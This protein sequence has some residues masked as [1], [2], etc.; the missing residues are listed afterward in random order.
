MKLLRRYSLV[1][2]LAIFSLFPQT[3]AR[4]Q[5]DV[6]SGFQGYLQLLAAR[7]RS[8]GVSEP[9]IQQMTWGLTF[10]PARGRAG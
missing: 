2:L 10:Q 3:A 8:E 5:S 6:E 7:A 1:A 4:A 9:T